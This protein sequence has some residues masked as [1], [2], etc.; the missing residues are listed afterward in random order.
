MLRKFSIKQQVRVKTSEGTYREPP[1]DVKG[2]T[3]TIADQCIADW[4]E[5][6]EIV[7]MET[8][9]SYY[10]EISETQTVLIGEDW[11]EPV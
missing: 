8:P 1:N 3:G 4:L 2:A 7:P 5:K 10:V 6:S 11:L 9:R